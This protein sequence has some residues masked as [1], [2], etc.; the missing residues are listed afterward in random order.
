MRPLQ[1]TGLFSLSE[2]QVYN[3]SQLSNIVSIVLLVWTM[4]PAKW[5]N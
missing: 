1:I 2:K 3:L 5:D 4:A